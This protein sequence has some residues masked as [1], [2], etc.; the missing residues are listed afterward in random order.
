M[1]NLSACLN[2]VSFN[3]WLSKEILDTVS[4]SLKTTTNWLNN[5]SM[6][7]DIAYDNMIKYQNQCLN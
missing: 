7:S 2:N 3:Y 1:H 5:V 6:N 4:S